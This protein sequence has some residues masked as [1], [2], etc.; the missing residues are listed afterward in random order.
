MTGRCIA[1]LFLLVLLANS[2]VMGAV[3]GGNV[4]CVG[5]SITAGVGATITY[6]NFYPYQLG[7][8]LGP[9]YTVGNYGHDGASVALE[10]GYSY[11]RLR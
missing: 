7:L 2:P 5:D 4:A 1:G 6:R 8:L 11:V 10:G 9:Q 3:A